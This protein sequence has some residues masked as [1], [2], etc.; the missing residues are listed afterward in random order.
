MKLALVSLLTRLGNND[1]E[2]GNFCQV[3]KPIRDG[4]RTGWL[5]KQKADGRPSMVNLFPANLS[6]KGCIWY[7][8]NKKKIT[9]TWDYRRTNPN[10]VTIRPKNNWVC[11][12]FPNNITLR[13]NVNR[14]RT[15]WK[16]PEPCNRYD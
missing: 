7:S 8:K 6:P 3:N 14:K 12:R 9:G 15:C 5:H 1:T 4:A 10:R 16:I 2:S 13:C 11:Q